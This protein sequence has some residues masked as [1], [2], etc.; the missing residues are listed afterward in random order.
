MSYEKQAKTNVCIYI[1][2]YIPRTQMTLVWL[3]KTLFWR[4]QPQNRGQT[5]SRFIYRQHHT[6]LSSERLDPL[7]R[8]WCHWVIRS[9][10]HSIL[11]NTFVRSHVEGYVSMLVWWCFTN[12]KF[13]V[14]MKEPFFLGDPLFRHLVVST[15]KT[16]VNLDHFPRGE[17][18]NMIETTVDGRILHH[19]G[20][21]KPCK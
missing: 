15:W 1:Y 17:N 10:L 11:N 7:R 8:I 14:Q 2:T 4:V 6:I 12:V 21:I 16:W 18:K 19:L 3:E 13:C 20:C 5:G 9:Y